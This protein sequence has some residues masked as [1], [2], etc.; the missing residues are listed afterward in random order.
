MENKAETLRHFE[1][2]KR[3]TITYEPKLE[4]IMRYIKEFIYSSKKDLNNFTEQDLVNYLNSK[5]KY[6]VRTINDVK[7]YLKTFIKWYFVDWSS[8]FRNLDKL[9]RNQTPPSA[10]K[11]NE[12]LTKEDVQ[13]LVQEET[14]IF[15]KAF[16]LT[17][18]YGGMRPC[19]VVNLTWKQISF[20]NDGAFITI[21]SKK[22]KKD[23]IKYVPNDVSFYLRKLQT[24]NSEL[25]FPSQLKTR[26]GL[27]MVGNA[28]YMRLQRLSMKALNRKIN[29]YQL[30]HSIATI[31]YDRDDIKDDDTAKQMGHSKS[32]KKNYEHLDVDR[33]KERAKKIWINAEDL[34]Q[35]KKN[36]LMETIKR[37]QEQINLIAARLKKMDEDQ[38]IH[39][40]V[41]AYLSKA[42]TIQELEVLAKQRGLKAPMNS[43]L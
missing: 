19:E 5:N 29:P 4:G 43:D 6:S 41:D 21:Y 34:P 9:C 2:F 36:E 10:Y 25:V 31:L 22:N 12:M 40:E 13:K 18:F 39:D 24:N 14:S 38:R 15:W 1:A 23:F 33:L 8:R 32:M 42:K 11:P 26:E 17:L 28:V 37:Q 27:P 20:E 30:R 35:E 16:W 3:T 7:V